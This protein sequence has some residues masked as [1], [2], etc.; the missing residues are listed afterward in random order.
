MEPDRTYSGV[1]IT[2]SWDTVRITCISIEVIEC[3]MTSFYKYEIGLIR[4]PPLVG[5]SQGVD[6]DRGSILTSIRVGRRG[7]YFRTL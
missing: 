2:C 4:V 7:G 6:D 3:T 5:G 1:R